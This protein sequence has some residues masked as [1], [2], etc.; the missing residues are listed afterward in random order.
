MVLG[1]EDYQDYSSDYEASEQSDGEVAEQHPL[2][3]SHLQFGP[4]TSVQALPG[5]Q[6]ALAAGA[7][8]ESV[9]VVG[10]VGHGPALR[11]GH[12]GGV[13][14]RHV[15]AGHGHSAGGHAGHDL[16]IISDAGGR[17]GE[18]NGNGESSGAGGS[19][20]GGGG[21]GACVISY[22]LACANGPGQSGDGKSVLECPSGEEEVCIDVTE[23]E[24]STTTSTECHDYED[25]DCEIEQK[26]IC[27][28]ADQTTCVDTEFAASSTLGSGSGDGEQC[29]SIDSQR[30]SQPKPEQVCANIKQVECNPETVSVCKTV[31]SVEPTEE[32]VYFNEPHCQEHQEQMCFMG[33]TSSDCPKS[34]VKECKYVTKQCP[35]FA[36]YGCQPK[37]ERVCNF[38]SKS[39]CQGKTA[40]HQCKTLASQKC[41]LKPQKQCI[42]VPKVVAREECEDRLVNNCKEKPSKE[43]LTV[44]KTECEPAPKQDV[45]FNIPGSG[46]GGGYFSTLTN[47]FCTGQNRDI[48]FNTDRTVCTSTGKTACFE[49]PTTTCREVPSKKCF[50]VKTPPT[51]VQVPKANC[52]EGGG[53]G[54]NGGGNGG[55]GGAQIH[56]IHISQPPIHVSPAPVHVSPAP[57]HVAP[58]PIHVAPAPI[59]VAPAPVHVA[60]APIHVAPA[61]IHVSTVPVHLSHVAAPAVVAPVLPVASHVHA[62]QTPNAADVVDLRISDSAAALPTATSH[63]RALPSLAPVLAA[64]RGSGSFSHIH[65][66]NQQPRLLG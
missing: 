14:H 4:S 54:G 11:V 3:H 1:D 50:T 35:P 32:C 52:L 59:H 63:D 58:A 45:C 61:P 10:V 56:S 30:C 13:G 27:I 46:G 28:K 19:N 51:L 41:T 65:F 26:E 12:H 18:G 15:G 7:L 22:E 6:P 53:G 44:Y 21:G 23:T 34:Q 36:E 40:S 29:R 48:C 38:V 2:S 5:L 62:D 9:P 39:S 57:I 55:S 33:F 42:S 31:V 25:V 8:V 37:K 43:C 16:F 60:P 49:I 47:R 17:G 24:C 66:G 20:G 64:G